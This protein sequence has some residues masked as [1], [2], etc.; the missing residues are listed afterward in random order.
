MHYFTNS[1]QYTWKNYLLVFLLANIVWLSFGSYLHILSFLYFMG[2]TILIFLFMLLS[3]RKLDWPV[4]V[5]VMLNFYFQ[6][7][8][9]QM[10][11][12]NTGYP[13]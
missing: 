2:K 4:I 7:H 10:F 8:M 13:D 3:N 1:V 11:I 6:L 12:S 9:Y 5:L